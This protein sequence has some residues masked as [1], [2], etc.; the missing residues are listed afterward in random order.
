MEIREERLITPTPPVHIIT[1]EPRETPEP[2]ADV[3]P[4]VPLDTELKKYIVETADKAGVDP[5]LVFAVIAVETGGTWNA[6]IEGDGGNSHGLMQ[7]Y[8]SCHTD[9]M[10]RLGVFDLTDPFQNVLV[11]IDLLGEL[12]EK[13]NG[14]VWAL[15]CYN[16]G[17][18]YANRMQENG[19]IS[20]YAERV[21]LLRDEYAK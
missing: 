1:M 15:H 8:A 17:E 18:A 10:E 7:I 4:T 21:L 12:M 3:Y 19:E 6:E 2:E 16:G 9:R 11:G 20:R 5:K 14:E 13:G